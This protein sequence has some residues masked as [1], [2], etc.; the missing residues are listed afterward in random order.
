M[1]RKKYIIDIVGGGI[2]GMASAYYLSHRFSN[3]HIRVWEKDETT[4]GLAGTFEFK[5]N[6]YLEK[7][8]HHIFLGDHALLQ[9]I[10]ELGMKDDIVSRPAA[11]GS[12]YVSK[13]Y[14]L[15]TPLD[16]LR[17][18]P[19]SFFNRFRMGFMVLAARFIKDWEKLDDLTA[20][21]YIKKY[22]GKKVF[23]V[24]WEPLLKGKFG[25]Y[26]D[27]VS[28]AWIWSKFVDRGSSRGK[29]GHEQLAYLKGGLGRLFNKIA[30]NLIANGHEVHTGK[31]IEKFLFE[32][33]II[34]GI[35]VSGEILTTDIVIGAIQVPDIVEL[36]GDEFQKYTLRL[37][38]IKFLANVC[39]VLSLKNSLSEFYWTNVTDTS[40]P[41]VGV[42][43]Q[44]KWVDKKEFGNDH[45]VY[46]SSYVTDDDK[47]NN[48][49]A[50]ELL[51]Y[52]LPYLQSMFPHFS[53]EDIYF[54]NLWKAPYTQPIVHKGYRH[55]VPE[56][57]SP[58]GNFF[59]CTM[60]QIYPN[61]RQVSNAVEK[62]KE[63]TDYIGKK[64]QWL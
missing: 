46:I 26:A 23:K 44:T 50:D 43:E 16:L 7:F 28:A 56:V 24:A 22:A 30:E 15:S 21:D 45:I 39:L 1:E 10:D 49:T 63:L 53:P 42:I 33:N 47:R 48:M 6:V 37:K 59:V 34:K 35:R 25:K 29:G 58:V 57:Q 51:D 5:E 41:F 36:F 19:L 20:E 60:A 4:G 18:K 31:Q 12:Y 40:A 38:K 3:I 9:L 11:T 2:S 8:Y 64:H 32:K 62:A 52:Y 14:R 27:E 61:D 54:K 17:F 55:S 13:P